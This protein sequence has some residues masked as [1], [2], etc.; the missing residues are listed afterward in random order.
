MYDPLFV[1]WYSFYYALGFL[2]SF[3]W[4]CLLL[5]FTTS[6]HIYII[7]PNHYTYTPRLTLTVRHTILTMAPRTG[8]HFN[9]TLTLLF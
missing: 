5:D 3:S 7:V 2:V 9:A 1:K 6:L 8:E 4:Y